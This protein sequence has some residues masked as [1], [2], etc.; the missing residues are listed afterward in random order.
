MSTNSFP[1]QFE[2][3]R[4]YECYI[5]IYTDMFPTANI[6]TLDFDHV[7]KVVDEAQLAVIKNSKY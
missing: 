7:R 4:I 3:K 2:Y 6:E 5:N 1:L